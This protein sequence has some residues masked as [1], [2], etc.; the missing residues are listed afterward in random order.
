MNKG[1]IFLCCACAILLFTIINLSIGPIVTGTVKR[2]FGYDWGLLNTAKAKD[3]YD[4]A[5]D[6]PN[7]NDDCLKYRAKWKLNEYTRKKECMIWN[8]HPLFLI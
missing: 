4:D 6:N 1:F 2:Y 5:K 8:I 7:C 3:D